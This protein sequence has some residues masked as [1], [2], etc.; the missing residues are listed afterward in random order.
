VKQG[1]RYTPRVT[2]YRTPGEQDEP[3]SEAREVVTP[4]GHRTRAI[5]LTDDEIARGGE[6]TIEVRRM[7]RCKLCGGRGCIECD[8]QGFRMRRATLA[9]AVQ[10]GAAAG[11]VVTLEGEGDTGL[12]GEGDV[13]VRLLM[14]KETAATVEKD[15]R[16]LARRQKSWLRD[17]AKASRQTK[18]R[19]KLLLGALAAVFALLGV[20]ALWKY[21][22]KNS[23]GESCERPGDCR[24]AMCVE[25]TGIRIGG[26]QTG[27]V[28]TK[29]CSQK[30][31]ADG[32]CPSGMACKAGVDV[33]DPLTYLPSS[34]ARLCA[35]R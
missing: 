15:D 5:T 2:A 33:I 10:A 12:S 17:R 4:D 3:P 35:P 34:Q 8:E 24:S 25:S 11:T 18:R 22:G 14:D 6:R 31:T 20:L 7:I 21:L 13:L 27:M 29:K 28:T 9:V 1:L 26:G 30:C 32:D 19:G 23:V 16:A